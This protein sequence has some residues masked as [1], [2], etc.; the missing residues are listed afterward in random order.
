MIRPLEPKKDMERVA[1]MWL[2]EIVRVYNFVTEPEKFWGK[3]L[4]EMKNV[5]RTAEGYVYEEDGI[6]K[7]F[8]TIKDHYIWDMVVDSQYQKKGIGTALLNF[9]MERKESLALGIFQKNQAGIEFFEKRG[10]AKAGV[11][12]SLEG[13]QKFDMIWRKEDV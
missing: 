9:V 2:S 8:I 1:D 6:I 13:H 12:T 11:Y 3:R 7:A 10:F 5:T 4:D